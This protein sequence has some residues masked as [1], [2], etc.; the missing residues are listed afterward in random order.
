MLPRAD[1]SGLQ[2]STVTYFV[3]SVSCAIRDH[4]D[5]E[6]ASRLAANK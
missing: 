6:D 1:A 2:A 4:S 3:L 5:S